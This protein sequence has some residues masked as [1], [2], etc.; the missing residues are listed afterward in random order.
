[1]RADTPV[2]TTPFAASPIAAI[3]LAAGL[4]RRMGGLPKAALEFGGRSL[5]EGL[6]A[7]LRGA[8]IADVSVVIG[9]YRDQLLAL[10]SRCNLHVVEHRQPG[11]DLIESQR[12]AL[13]A[14]IERC[15]GFDLLL[16]V[17][18]LPLLT[19]AH[20]QPLL[21]AWR[22]RA[23]GIHAQ[24]PVV[25]GVRGHPVLLSWHAVQAIAATERHTGIRAWLAANADTVSP[26]ST[27][28]RAYVTD[29]DTPEDLAAL[30]THRALD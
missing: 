28:E 1:M 18:D 29:V 14:H 3:L 12:L 15:P 11:A 22:Q 30:T 20:V 7:A 13:D 25:D 16:S 5:L 9:P 27:H 26:V 10:A 17:A 6:S 24:M 23:E 21:Q 19:A 2:T 8:G 4:G